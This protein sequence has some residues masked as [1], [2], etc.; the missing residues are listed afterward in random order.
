MVTEIV[1]DILLLDGTRGLI[2]NQLSK[3]MYS[4]CNVLP[5]TNK[6]TR[7]NGKLLKIRCI[8][9]TESYVLAT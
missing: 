6:Y 5:E 3:S 4:H 2:S 9:Y 8:Y 7:L 1:L